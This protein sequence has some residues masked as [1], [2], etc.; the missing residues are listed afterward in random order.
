MG[1]MEDIDGS[2]Q[3]ILRAGT[4]GYLWCH[5]LSFLTQRKIPRTFHVD[6][7]I[8]SV[9][10]VGGQEWVYL[11]DVEGPWG[12]GHPSCH[13][14]SCLTLRKIPW[15][16]CADNAQACPMTIAFWAGWVLK[17]LVCTLLSWQLSIYSEYAYN[18]AKNKDNDMKL[19]GYDPWGLPSTSITP[20]PKPNLTYPHLSLSLIHISEPTRLRRNSYAVFCLKKK[21]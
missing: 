17:S 15:K 19:S 8:R 3:E 5:V 13:G 11:E 14:W 6:I 1:V 2:S 21:N 18:S 9:S 7:F 4:M 20:K 12:Q 16:F 10:G